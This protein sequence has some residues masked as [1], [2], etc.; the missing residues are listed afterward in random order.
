MLNIKM[1]RQIKSRQR[2]LIKYRTDLILKMIKKAKISRV[3]VPLKGMPDLHKLHIA[4]G[5]K[6][7]AQ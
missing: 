1:T 6:K 4:Q 7:I 2:T 3:R 5:K